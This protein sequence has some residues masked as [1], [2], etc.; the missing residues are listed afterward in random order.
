VLVNIC[1]YL[2]SDLHY[3]REATL[4]LA[5]GLT[6]EDLRFRAT[7]ATNS[8]GFL[9]WHIGRTEDRWFNERL[10]KSPQVWVNGGWSQK[11]GLPAG[12][13]GFGYTTEQVEKLL[14]PDLDLVLAYM[15]AVHTLS[16]AAVLAYDP[17]RL[18]ATVLSDT[19]RPHTPF[20]IFRQVAHHENQHNGQIDF[21]RGN[22]LHK[23]A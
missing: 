23:P 9:L 6:P 20:Q 11:L 4:R 21:I 12:D 14:I 7:P 10:A 1:E 5:R 8:I 16:Q 17:A 3:A 19:T 18:D 15:D 22:Y 2:A 13:T